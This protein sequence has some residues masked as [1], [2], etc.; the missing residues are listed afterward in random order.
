MFAIS[1]VFLMYFDTKFVTNHTQRTSALKRCASAELASHDQ[2]Y[3]WNHMAIFRVNVEEQLSTIH[4]VF[5]T[6][7]QFLW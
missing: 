2:L 3:T 4:G 6:I 1:S 5:T 7:I